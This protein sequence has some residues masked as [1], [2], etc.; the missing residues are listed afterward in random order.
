VRRLPTLLL[1]VALAAVLLLAQHGQAGD[2]AAQAATVNTLAQLRALI[3]D[4]PGTDYA[5]LRIASIGVDA[6]VG[7]HIIGK[8]ERMPDPLGPADVAWY[9]FQHYPGM[10]GAPGMDG[11]AVFSGHVDYHA[12]VPYAGVR[13]RGPG[14]FAR[15]GDLRP[16]DTVEVVRQGVTHR[17][18]V[19]WT[20]T[21][22]ADAAAWG[23]IWD[24]NV[25]IDSITLFTCSGSFDPSS[26]A[27]SHRTVVRA[28][29]V[30]GTPRRFPAAVDGTWAY[31]VSGTTHPAALAQNQ[32]S[33]VL[34]MYG[35][36]EVS[37]EW[38]T[39]IPGA[40][41]FANTLLG[42]LRVDSFVIIRVR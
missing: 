8:G 24:A 35:Q 32:R 37:G 3:G 36:D 13:Y 1:T 2:V 9:D 41:A 22:A 34:A 29:R 28:E 27:Y 12:V 4:A 39:Y 7:A 31:G 21:L 17:Y 16:G 30:I 11:N 42:R 10:G 6:P 33:P 38:L 19:S 14:V 18:A 15:L 40:P 5:R 25:P 20:R 26:V 23:Q